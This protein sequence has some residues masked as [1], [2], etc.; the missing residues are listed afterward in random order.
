L[1][2]RVRPEALMVIFVMFK[3]PVG[4][5][6]VLALNCARLPL[7]RGNRGRCRASGPGVIDDIGLSAG[8]ARDR[9]RIGGMVELGFDRE[10]E[11]VVGCETNHANKRDGGKSNDEDDVTA[12]VRHKIADK[13][14]EP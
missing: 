8:N 1:P 2:V 13:R 4:K 12:P 5:V 9:S 7:A 10:H 11:T 14:F 3:V 6:P